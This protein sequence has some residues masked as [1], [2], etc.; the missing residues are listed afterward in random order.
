MARVGIVFGLVLCGL[1]A[2]ALVWTPVKSPTQFIPMM[3]GIPILFCGV[4]ALNPHRRRHAM[5][6]ASG[7]AMLGTVGGAGTSSYWLMTLAGGEVID[8]NS[9]N[10]VV[11]MTIVCAVFVAVCVVSFISTRRRK[12]NQAMAAGGLINPY[13]PAEQEAGVS[14]V[15]SRESA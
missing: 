2:V 4:V 9:L 12:R 10:L 13:Q 3:L 1:T 14:P 11:A 15:N 7:I 8:R 6:A 5:H